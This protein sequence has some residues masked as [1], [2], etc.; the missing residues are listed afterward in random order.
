MRGLAGDLRERSDAQLAALLLARPDVARPAPTDLTSLA[1][2]LGSRGS[3]QRALESLTAGELQVLGAVLGVARS[4]HGTEVEVTA[5][6]GAAALDHHEAFTLDDVEAVR[7]ALERLWDLALLWRSGDELH[8]VR[9]LAELVTPATDGARSAGLLDVPEPV[10]RVWPLVDVDRGAGEQGARL[11]A[12]ITELALAW[13]GDDRPEPRTAAPRQLRSGGLAA[14]DLALAAKRFGVPTHEIAFVVELA[15]AAGLLDADGELD[16]VWAPTPAFD[17]WRRAPVAE[18]W[19]A[20][21][22]AWRTMPQAPH[23]VGGRDDAD[24]PINA[25][26][27]AAWWPPVV[28]A[29]RLLLDELASLPAGFAP[30]VDNLLLRLRWRRPVL[31]LFDETL[32]SALLAECELLGLTSRGAASSVGRGE[33]AQPQLP[34]PVDRMVLQAD[35]TAIVTGAPTPDLADLLTLCTVVE[36]RGGAT[37]HRFTPESVAAALD[38]GWSAQSLLAAL[39]AASSTPVPQPLAFLVEDAERRHGRVRLHVA[40]TVLTSEDPVVLDELAATRSLARL[41]FSRVAPTVLTAQA[42][43]QIVLQAA[44]AAGVHPLVE[45]LLRGAGALDDP[46]ADDWDDP[47]AND[48]APARGYRARPRWGRRQAVVSVVDADAASEVVAHLRAAADPVL[49]NGLPTTD[50]VAIVDQLREAAAAGRGVQLG[51]AGNDGSTRRGLFSPRR[52]QAGQVYGT[53]GSSPVEQVLVAHRIT[54]VG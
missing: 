7:A 33:V 25:L 29:R 31:R 28:R 36:S 45:G 43:P 42:D 18:Q 15:R 10:G 37:T 24:K 50:P 41:G 2:R 52:I 47:D 12:T 26:S 30:T 40:A 51:Y 23:L 6:L 1:A 44:R 5:A 17:T 22:N 54:G 38:L 11:V 20:L 53:W 21:A 13:G 4:G 34:E 8:P 3:V 9:I 46:D 16:A 27:S 19:E 48:E 49:D 32:V 39:A 14:R 35:L